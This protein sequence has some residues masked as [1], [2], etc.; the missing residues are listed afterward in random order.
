MLSFTNLGWAI[1]NG[2]RT[3]K[4][5]RPDV[6]RAANHLLRM[7]VE[8]RLRLCLAPPDYFSQQGKD[9]SLWLLHNIMKFAIY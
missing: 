4:A 7:S 1:K 2:F 3:A 6:Y 8:G 9:I 5:A